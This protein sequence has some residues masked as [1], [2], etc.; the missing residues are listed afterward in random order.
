M[1]IADDL[2]ALVDDPALCLPVG[3]HGMQPL[4]IM[5]ADKKS[6]QANPGYFLPFLDAP[7][8]NAGVGSQ[9]WGFGPMGSATVAATP[10]EATRTPSKL[11]EEAMLVRASAGP[12]A[13][14][15]KKV[16][17]EVWVEFRLL[18]VSS[19]RE[20]RSRPLA[21]LTLSG[22]VGFAD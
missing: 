20:C 9:S 8:S 14:H 10:R 16:G 12:A 1:A 13:G 6:A 3:A 11:Y 4:E 15:G 22:F 2:L 19:G 5:Q 21:L 17:F 18:T 7:V